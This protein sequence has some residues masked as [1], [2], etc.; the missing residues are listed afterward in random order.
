MAPDRHWTSRS[1]TQ[2]SDQPTA[3]CRHSRSSQSIASNQRKANPLGNEKRAPA[4]LWT[5]PKGSLSRTPSNLAYGPMATR[6]GLHSQAA[7]QLKYSGL[8]FPERPP[9][10]EAV[11]QWP[12]DWAQWAGLGSSWAGLDWLDPVPPSVAHL[13]APTEYPVPPDYQVPVPVTARARPRSTGCTDDL[14]PRPPGQSLEPQTPLA[15]KPKHPALPS[16]RSFAVSPHTLASASPSRP[17]FCSCFLVLTPSLESPP[18]AACCFSLATFNERCARLVFAAS[19][20][21]AF[22][23]LPTAPP[24]LAQPQSSAKKNCSCHNTHLTSSHLVSSCLVVTHRFFFF[25]SHR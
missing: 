12:V 9:A 8:P 13:A 7:R 6:W 22:E 23:K 1:I 18:I 4:C 5:S 24:G 3:N 15:P 11:G 16:S 25:S 19:I 20:Q 2:L 21:R 17:S 10:P 14:Q